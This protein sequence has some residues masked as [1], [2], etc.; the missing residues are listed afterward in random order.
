MFAPPNGPGAQLR[1]S[2]HRRIETG[3]R[4]GVHDAGGA[5]SDGSLL[6]LLVLREL[7]LV[8]VAVVAHRA[9]V[10]TA[11][12]PLLD[13][14]PA[15]VAA[16]CVAI[17]QV[18]AARTLRRWTRLDCPRISFGGLRQRAGSGLS[19]CSRGIHNVSPR[20]LSS[21]FD[22]A[23]YS[24]TVSPEPPKSS[25]KSLYFGRPSRIARTFSP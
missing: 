20:V 23:A 9:P 2:P 17:H 5:G 22:C 16:P 15:R 24:G 11:Q 12:D 13:R 14:I 10:D 6:A 19:S 7:R 25:G 4:R 3:S 21:I 1:G 18:V 8:L